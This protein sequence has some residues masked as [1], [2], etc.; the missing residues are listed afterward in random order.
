MLAYVWR[1]TRDAETGAAWFVFEKYSQAISRRCRASHERFARRASRAEIGCTAQGWTVSD[2]LAARIT[3]ISIDVIYIAHASNP[4]PAYHY[5]SRSIGRIIRS[6]VAT[7]A[8]ELTQQKLTGNFFK[9]LC[10][11]A[12]KYWELICL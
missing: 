4:D 2:H 12:Y 3:K 11:F 6:E 10:L 8:R 1:R 9:P 7:K 5:C